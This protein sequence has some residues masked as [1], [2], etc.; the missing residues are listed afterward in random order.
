MGDPEA[1]DVSDRPVDA[2]DQRAPAT[3]LHISG[4]DAK[5]WA[6]LTE[7]GHLHGTVHADEVALV[8]RHVDLSDEVLDTTRKALADEGIDLDESV[9]TDDTAGRRRCRRCALPA[10]DVDDERLLSRRRRSWTTAGRADGATTSTSDGVRMYLREIGQVDLLTTEDER[11]LAQL[12]EE[13]T[14]PRGASTRRSAVDDEASGAELM[15][16]VSRGERAKSELT[17]ANLR[18]VVSIAKRYSGRGMQLLDLIQEGNLGLMR[19]SPRRSPSPSSCSHA[20]ASR[21]SAS[22]S[23]CRSIPA[24]T[25]PAC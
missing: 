4:V 11:R 19:A 14:T 6:D 17:Q 12:I 7:R 5:E 24:S 23:C 22:A 3:T 25:P 10:D 2:P 18:L 9:D 15:R 8:L 13:G 20:R 16:I 1:P 21:S